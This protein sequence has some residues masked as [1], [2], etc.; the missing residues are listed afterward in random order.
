VRIVLSDPQ[1]ALETTA[2]GGTS[3][4]FDGS[5]WIYNWATPSTKGCYVLYVLLS[6][7]SSRQANFQLK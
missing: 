4:K 6:D 3:L 5:Q 2:T 1:D 7:G